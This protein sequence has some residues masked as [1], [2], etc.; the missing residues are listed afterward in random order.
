MRSL[1]A[2]L[3]PWVVVAVFAF[4]PWASA[5][6]D[7]SPSPKNQP[8]VVKSEFIFEKAPFA[9]SHASTIAETK[10]GLIA[11]W[12]GGSDEGEKDVGI[13][14]SLHDGTGEGAW[15]APVEVATGVTGK[16]RFPCWNP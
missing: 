8:G 5:G 3:S 7:T 4:T 11:A 6:V 13:W 16:D 1:L 9:S 15:S 2:S 10:S 12:F 14:T